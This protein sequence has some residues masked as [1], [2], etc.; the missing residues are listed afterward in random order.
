VDAQGRTYAV[1]NYGTPE[2]Y[3]IAEV[4]LYDPLDPMAGIFHT[5][6]KQRDQV[7]GSTGFG[8]FEIWRPRPE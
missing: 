6:T 8:G 2:G 3:M 5:W 4:M 7:L 1:T